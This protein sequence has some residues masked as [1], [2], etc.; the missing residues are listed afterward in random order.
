MRGIT[1]GWT[2]ECL[3]APLTARLGVV[4][5]SRHEQQIAEK[6]QLPE[7]RSRLSDEGLVLQRRITLPVETAFGVGAFGSLVALLGVSE[8]SQQI[9]V[10]PFPS[11]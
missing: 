2:G 9:G 7:E 10:R 3:R 6:Y 1:G 8:P 11:G 4:Y 5:K